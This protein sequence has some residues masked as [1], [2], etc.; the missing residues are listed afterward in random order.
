[1]VGSTGGGLCGIKLFFSCCCIG[2]WGVGFGKWSIV[3][4]MITRSNKPAYTVGTSLL[5]MF[6]RTSGCARVRAICN[7]IGKVRKVV[8][9]GLIG[10]YSVV[11]ASSSI[12]LV[13]RAPSAMLNSYE[14]GLPTCSDNSGMCRAVIGALQVRSVRTFF[15][16][17]NGSSVSIIAGLSGCF[18]TGKVGSVITV[19]VPGAVSGSLPKASRAPNFN[20]TTGCVTAAVRRVVH[21]DDICTLP[22]IAVIRVVKQSAN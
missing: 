18:G 21:S 13:H 8:C 11:T 16:V 12:R 4:V 9:G 14:C 1:M 20:S 2:V 15:C 19:N 7:S 22:S 17:N 10:L 6:H 3:G 5:N